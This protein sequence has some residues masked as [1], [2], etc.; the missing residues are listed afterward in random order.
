[1]ITAASTALEIAAAVRARQVSAAAFTERA[2]AALG[3]GNAR[4]NAF[5]AITA[6]RAREEAAAV[7]A[8]IAAGR[9]PGPLAGVPFAVKDLFDIAGIV[10]VAGSKINRG[11]PPASRDATAV[12]A[13]ARRRGGLPR[14]AQHGRVRLRFRHRERPRRR[15]AES[16]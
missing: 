16:A 6:E 14:R 10:T 3:P 2:L 4:I 15:D 13:P 11:H 8:A 1:M 12:R 7:D 5:T 9:H